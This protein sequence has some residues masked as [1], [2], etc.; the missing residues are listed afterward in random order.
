MEKEMME[1]GR[2]EKWVS[3]E[4]LIKMNRKLMQKL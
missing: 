1:R 4:E 2:T 3:V